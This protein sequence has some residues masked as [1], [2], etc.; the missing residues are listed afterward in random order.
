MA[1]FVLGPLLFGPLSEYVGRRPVIIL[2][3]IGYLIFTLACSGAPSYPVLLVFRL[4]SGINAA[5]PVTVASGM[6]ADILDD[7]SQRGVAIALY[8]TFNTLGALCGPLISGFASEAS[9]KWAF[10]AAA[11]IAAPALPLVLLLPETFA[12]VLHNKEIRWNAKYGTRQ[13]GIALTHLRPFNV[14]K[15]FL[16]P[17][18]LMLT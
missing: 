14:H 16:R 6:F 7:P 9:W 15:I 12:P 3:S 18:T 1:G 8:M 11:L 4:L 5:A 2:S 17:I 13:D 10:W